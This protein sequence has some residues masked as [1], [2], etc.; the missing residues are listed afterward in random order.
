MA[1]G[2]TF[3]HMDLPL[4]QLQLPENFADSILV[5][6]NNPVSNLYITIAGFIMLYLYP[7]T[8]T[9]YLVSFGTQCC[10]GSRNSG[11]STLYGITCTGQSGIFI[12]DCLYSIIP[13]YSA[14]SCSLQNEMTV[15][16]Y[17]SANCNTGDIRLMDGNSTSEGRVEFCSQGLWGAI[18]ASN[19]DSNDAKVV[20]RQLGFPWKC[21][22]AIFIF[23]S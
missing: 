10:Y 3:A 9:L 22:L 1:F 7:I 5:Q 14:G 15:G 2:V 23:D 16:C 12:Q 17:E 20:C 18:T 4:H 21:E 11:N 8:M 13:G 19:W 6:D